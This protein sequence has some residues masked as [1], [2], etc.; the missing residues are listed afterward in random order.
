[1][2]V[3]MLGLLL[4]LSHTALSNETEDLARISHQP[5]TATAPEH[6]LSGVRSVGVLNGLS[7]TPARSSVANARDDTLMD[8][9]A[10]DT[11]EKYGLAFT[12]PPAT[13]A[14]TLAPPTTTAA[15]IAIIIDDIGYNRQQAHHALTLPGALT[16]AVIPHTPNAQWFA[17]QAK[18]R[19]KEIMLH[20]PM[21]HINGQTHP[22][23]GVLNAQ[24]DKSSFHQML[25][26]ALDSLPYASG[27]NNHMGS[28]LTQK[29][30]PM[31][32][33]MQ[34]LNQ[35]NLY[36]I[37]SR[38][39]SNSIAWQVARQ[40]QIPTLKRDIFLDHQRDSAFIEAQFTQLIELAKRR[41]YAIGIG[42]P[43]PE[44][45]DFLARQIPLLAKDNIELIPTSQI[46]EIHANPLEFP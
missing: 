27:L 21:S 18:L 46:V 8:A 29:E 4:T 43:Y 11:G 12:A 37:D 17:E 16:Y 31:A 42:H 32:W 23:A 1:M 3:F 14:D 28:L 9:L 19:Q 7:S 13:A 35:R 15:Q 38:T 36:F 10:T 30:Q 25:D 34:A 6:T 26:H 41:G 33:L 2:P 40:Y 20:A 44:T 45:L 22:E 24:M 5:P 39:T